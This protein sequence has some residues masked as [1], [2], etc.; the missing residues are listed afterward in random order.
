MAG[1]V[2]GAGRA[3]RAYAEKDGRGYPDWALRYAPIVRRLSRGRDLRKARIL[4]V[5]AN[6]NGI[7]R[8]A[9]VKPVA[10]DVAVE[11]LRAARSAQDVIPVAASV[12]ALPFIKD[13]FDVVVSVDTFEHLPQGIRGDAVDELCRVLR[14]DGSAAVAFPTGPAAEAAERDVRERYREFTGETLRWFEE[15]SRE[16][17]PDPMAIRGRFEE[18]AGRTHRVSSSKNATILVWRWLWYVLLCGWPGRGN[19]FFQA[20]ARVLTPVLCRMHWGACYRRI[21]WVE[22]KKRG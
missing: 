10:V 11:H 3:L 22:A 20:A 8:F 18:S 4:E 17:L 21:I 2:S 7:G 16:G 19:A 12:D 14:E 6:E 9:G 1:I 15:H 13:A 5:G